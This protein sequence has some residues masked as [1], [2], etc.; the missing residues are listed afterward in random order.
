MKEAFPDIAD[1]T[2]KAA[3]KYGYRIDNFVEVPKDGL[4]RGLQGWHIN[5]YEKASGVKGTI[6]VDQK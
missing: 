2:G 3:S 6:L 5:Y 4:K 1:E